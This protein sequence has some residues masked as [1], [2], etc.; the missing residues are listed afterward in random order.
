MAV[1]PQG[2]PVAEPQRAR[3]S[4]DELRDHALFPAADAE[5]SRVTRDTHL[6]TL[7]GW[8]YLVRD[9]AAETVTRFFFSDRHPGAPIWMESRRGE[10]VLLEVTQIGRRR[11]GELAEG[12]PETAPEPG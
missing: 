2:Q 7:E 12:D 4:W 5:R 6:G 8:L 9:P 11:P 1:D 10:Q 3:S